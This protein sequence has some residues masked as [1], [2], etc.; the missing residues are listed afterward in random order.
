[1]TWMCLKLWG[2]DPQNCQILGYPNLEESNIVSTIRDEHPEGFNNPKRTANQQVH[3]YSE[4][5]RIVEGYTFICPCVYTCIAT[6]PK[7][8]EKKNCPTKIVVN[9][10]T[11]LSFQGCYDKYWYVWSSILPDNLVP[12]RL[13]LVPKQASST[14]SDIISSFLHKNTRS[15]K[16][17]S[18]QKAVKKTHLPSGNLT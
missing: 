6:T 12:I 4:V 16:Q 13:T 11:F 10:R 3:A 2:S 7:K 1:M 5:W 15:I 8:G 17:S 14:V 9:Y 18:S